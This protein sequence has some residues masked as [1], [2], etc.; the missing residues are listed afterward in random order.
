MTRSLAYSTTMESITHG[1]LAITLSTNVFCSD[2]GWICFR[3]FFLLF[4]LL[5]DFFLEDM[6]WL[7]QPSANFDEFVSQSGFYRVGKKCGEMCGKLIVIT[8]CRK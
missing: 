1:N 8:W 4:L 7:I 6:T 5:P 3:G 2:V